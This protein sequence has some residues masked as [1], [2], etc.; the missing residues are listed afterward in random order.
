ML[1]AKRL[2]QKVIGENVSKIQQRMQ[3]DAAKGVRQIME[4]QGVR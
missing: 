4:E 2:E 3:E 1:E